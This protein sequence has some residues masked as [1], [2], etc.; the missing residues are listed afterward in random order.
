MKTFIQFEDAYQRMPVRLIDYDDATGVLFLK[1]GDTFLQTTSKKP[2]HPCPVDAN[3]WFDMRLRAPDG[4]TLLLHNALTLSTSSHG[5]GERKRDAY[6]A[7]IFPNLVVDNA[8]A[9]AADNKV[10]RVT[11]RLTGLENY[12]YYQHAEPLLGFSGKPEQVDALKAMRFEHRDKADPFLPSR[13]YVM[14]DYPPYLSFGVHDRRYQVWAGGQESMGSI[15]CIRTEAYPVATISFDDAVDLNAALERVWE[16]RTL[17]S[18]MAVL[19]LALHSISVAGSADDGAT[20]ADL[21]LPNLPHYPDASRG[22]YSLSPAYL[23]LNGWAERD[24]LAEGMQRW[25]EHG[26]QRRTFRGK[27]YRV[28]ESMNRRSDPNDLIEL[29]SATESLAELSGK[30]A[31][32]RA[33]LDA[34]ADAAHAAAVSAGATVE[35]QRIRGVIGSLQRPSLAARYEA[36]GKRT[37]PP[38]LRR[39][40]QLLARSAAQIRH[41]SAHGGAMDD[42]VQPR[43][44]PTIQA[45]AGLAARFDLESCGIPSQASAGGRAMTKRRFDDGIDL[46]RRIEEEALGGS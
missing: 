3:G 7:E 28:I 36:L 15:H 13:V 42:Q 6:G 5:W 39:D 37:T 23:P 35:R 38:L 30:E 24:A 10:G 9:L 44:S 32:P 1:G 21:Y 22:H 18:E 20:T 33:T 12:F 2:L 4:R 19:P 34:M 43:V 29:A 40:A 8:D 46:L 14:H 27:L 17:F 16:W 26:E 41:A 45:L 25:L 11:F 31:V